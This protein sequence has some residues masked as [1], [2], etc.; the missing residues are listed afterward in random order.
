MYS[1]AVV[2]DCSIRR[3]LA[4]KLKNQ[5]LNS[6]QIIHQ[7]GGQDGTP[8]VQVQLWTTAPR[9]IVESHEK[10]LSGIRQE[11]ESLIVKDSKKFLAQSKRIQVSLQLKHAAY[12]SSNVWHIATT[13]CESLEQRMPFR[14]AMT[15]AIK[16]AN[17]VERIQG[18]KVQ[19][20]GRLNGAEI[21]RTEWIR[22]GQLPLTTLRSKI[23]YI[24][25]EA[26]TLYGIVG[27]KIWVFYGLTN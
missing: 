8:I 12:A 18:I 6:F 9:L 19:L 16:D 21:A 22:E 10:G 13:I 27:V 7:Y 2:I 14:R 20:S 17:Q 1:K 5:R 23:D 3:Y 26:H 11:I 25:R 24:H 15:K 4:T